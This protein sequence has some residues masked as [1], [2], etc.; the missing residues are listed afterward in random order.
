MTD[1]VFTPRGT[2]IAYTVRSDGDDDPWEPGVP[3]YPAPIDNL[4]RQL[5]PNATFLSSSTR[6]YN[7]HAYAW[8]NGYYN[9]V[10]INHPAEDNFWTD[11]SYEVISDNY[12]THFSYSGDHSAKTSGTLDI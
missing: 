1:P 11:G 10:W 2:T 8:A 5:F 9:R 4:Y 3:F 6:T 7:C 12:A